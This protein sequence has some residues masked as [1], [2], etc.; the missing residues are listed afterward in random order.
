[1]LRDIQCGE[2]RGRMMS[3]GDAAK[4]PEKLTCGLVRPIAD[5]DGYSA[6]H[7]SDVHDIVVDALDSAGFTS[8]IV[9]ESDA[10]GV[11]HG[12]IVKNLYDVDLVVC[13]VSGK[14]PNV[15]FELG[16]RLAFD[17]PTIVIKDDITSYS[18][19]TSPIE[20]IPYPRDLRYG[21]MVEFKAKLASKAVATV[22]A[23]NDPDYKS[24]LQHFGPIRV[25]KL[26]HQEVPA[27]QYIIDEIRDI[28]AAVQQLTNGM[29]HGVPIAP[30]KNRV[31]RLDGSTVI[32]KTKRVNIDGIN[33]QELQSLLSEIEDYPGGVLALPAVDSSGSQILNV[34]VTDPKAMLLWEA[35]RR[36]ENTVNRLRGERNKQHSEGRVGAQVQS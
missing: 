22:N 11:I 16:L 17:K 14:N 24:F 33:I 20:H 15:M 1:M 36:I 9:S 18:F 21:L 31:V 29:H 3:D 8:R 23:P 25:P 35:T 19:D 13:D 34:T 26:E 28:K 2:Y 32:E 10:I 5:M 6:Q 27:E 4:K 7:W 30:I 12:R